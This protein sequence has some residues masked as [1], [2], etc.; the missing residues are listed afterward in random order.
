LSS[1]RTPPKVPRLT[2]SLYLARFHQFDGPIGDLYHTNPVVHRIIQM[3]VQG[4]IVTKEEALSQMVID[5]AQNWDKHLC[6][7]GTARVASASRGCDSAL[8]WNQMSARA[9]A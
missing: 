2:Q 4:Q 1:C 8:A 9:S 6:E 7:N 3:Y 5:L